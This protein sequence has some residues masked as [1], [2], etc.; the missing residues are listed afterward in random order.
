MDI[1]GRVIFTATNGLIMLGK[2]LA[3]WINS[4]IFVGRFEFKRN[5]YG[6]DGK[7][8]SLRSVG[9][10]DDGGT[11]LVLCGQD[12]VYSRVGEAGSIPHLHPAPAFR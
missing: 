9:F 8:G 11:K 6:T 7:G 10:P 5:S 4:L 3:E 2:Y 12:H 1:S